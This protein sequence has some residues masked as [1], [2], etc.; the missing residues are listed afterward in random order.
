MFH[1]ATKTKNERAGALPQNLLGKAPEPVGEAYDAL[2][3][4]L[5]GSGWGT[6]AHPHG[7]MTP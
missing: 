4:P 7:I 3:G 6:S 5:V 1:C 2:L